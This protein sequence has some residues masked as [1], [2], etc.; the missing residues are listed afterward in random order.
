MSVDY[1]I[2]IPS[3][4]P[5]NLQFCLAHIVTHE[6]TL[7]LKRVIVV[8]DGLGAYKPPTTIIP[9]VKPFN[10]ARNVNLGIKKALE[11]GAKVVILLNDDALLISRFG[12]TFLSEYAVK[13]PY[14]VVSAAIQGIVCNPAQKVENIPNQ[15]VD[16]LKMLAFI[17][18][19]IPK[20]IFAKVGLL[21]EQFDHAGYGAE[22][23][24]Y[25]I[26][27]LQAGVGMEAID[28]CVVDHSG[29]LCR[30]TFRSDPNWKDRMNVNL[31]RLRE[32]W[33]LSDHAAA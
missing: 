26:R 15:Y 17:A 20:G 31:A 4:T 5:Q 11:D 12:F 18:V 8:D 10:F 14:I 23:N 3:K 19:A 29:R 9:G 16:D 33:N 1:R 6:P 7:D 2:V 13:G 25:S 32:K 22:D 21:D 30:S 24:D 28:D 27:C